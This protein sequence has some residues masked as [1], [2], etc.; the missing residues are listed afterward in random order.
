VWAQR[1]YQ[2]SSREPEL[3]NEGNPIHP[4][5]MPTEFNALAS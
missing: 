1:L 5:F 4:C 2:D 3:V